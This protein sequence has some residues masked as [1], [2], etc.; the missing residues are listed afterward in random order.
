MYIDSFMRGVKF[1]NDDLAGKVYD[2]KVGI[3]ERGLLPNLC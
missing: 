2:N 3:W 1:R